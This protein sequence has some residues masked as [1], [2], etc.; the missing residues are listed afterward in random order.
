VNS[1]P[2]PKNLLT[3]STFCFLLYTGCQV[4]HFSNSLL[5]MCQVFSFYCCAGGTL[6]A[7]T[8]VLTIYQIYHWIHPL[9]HSPSSLPSPHPGITSTGLIFPFVPGILLKTP[10]LF[11]WLHYI[12][13]NLPFSSLWQVWQCR[14]FKWHISDGNF[15]IVTVITVKL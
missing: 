12:C 10:S 2:S 14:K 11:G 4:A 7:F 15:F 8:K 9:H 6:L 13:L 1:N 3:V 5:H